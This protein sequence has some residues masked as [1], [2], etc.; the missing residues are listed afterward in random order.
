MFANK[1]RILLTFRGDVLGRARVFPGLKLGD[2][3]T[4]VSIVRRALE[5]PIRKI[6]ETTGLGGSVVVDQVKA[7]TQTT[8]GFDAETNEY[9]AGGDHRPDQGRAY[10]PAAYGVDRVVA[11]DDRGA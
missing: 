5:E 10:R 7:A 1:T 9:V 3:A 8:H 11:L 2:E 6:V 4:G